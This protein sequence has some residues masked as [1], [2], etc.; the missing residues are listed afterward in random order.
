MEKTTKTILIVSSVLALGG[1][2]F[3]IIK[4]RNKKSSLQNEIK[5]FTPLP[6]EQTTTT[7]KNP[8]V[9]GSLGL[10]VPR[11]KPLNFQSLTEML[12]GTNW[13]KIGEQVPSK[14]TTSKI[15]TKEYGVN[16]DALK[17]Y[18]KYK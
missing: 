5:E 15:Y 8:N 3:L 18:D 10:E 14:T 7:T 4:G 13:L 1:I 9:L 12:K 11:L 6:L 17:K 2:A 16:V